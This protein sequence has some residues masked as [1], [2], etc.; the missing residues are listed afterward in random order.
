VHARTTIDAF[1]VRPIV[2]N[3]G[4]QPGEHNLD[5]STYVTSDKPCHIPL[6]VLHPDT[7]LTTESGAEPFSGQTLATRRP[8]ANTYSESE[9]L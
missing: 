4:Q 1:P 9:M 7:L 2:D 6:I 5:Q 3:Q 8:A